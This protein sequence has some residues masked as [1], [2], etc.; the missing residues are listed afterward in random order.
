MRRAG[1][2]VAALA[3]GTLV[4]L[5]VY[6]HARPGDAVFGLVV[7]AAALGVSRT[8]LPPRRA[9]ARTGIGD[10]ASPA[11]GA[12][13]NPKPGPG[14]ERTATREGSPGRE[15]SGVG[16]A[17]LARLAA[18][19]L[20][21]VLRDSWRIARAALDTAPP[22][23]DAFVEVPLGGRSDTLVGILALMETVPPGSYLVDVDERRGTALYHAFDAAD[24]PDV[25]RRQETG[26]SPDA[27]PRRGAEEEP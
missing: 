7:A 3:G 16:F 18:T 15:P 22:P 27:R 20:W 2:L 12:G 26:L 14:S 9:R 13:A 24:V 5:G 8:V 10:A 17:S 6:G 25:R 21:S 11:A 1:I 23:E 19:T 4:F